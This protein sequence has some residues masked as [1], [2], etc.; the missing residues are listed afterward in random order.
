MRILDRIYY[1]KKE[2]KID[3]CSSFDLYTRY[4][5]IRVLNRSNIYTKRID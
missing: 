4:L 5:L 1:S 3:L 2:L